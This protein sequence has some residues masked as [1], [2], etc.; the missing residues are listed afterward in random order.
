MHKKVAFFNVRD[1]KGKIHP[2]E[3]LLQVYYLSLS[4][5][6]IKRFVWYNLY[7]SQSVFKF[8]L[9]YTI[10]QVVHTKFIKVVFTSCSYQVH[11][12]CFYKYSIFKNSTKMIQEQAAVV[13]IIALIS[14]K[15]KSRKKRKKEKSLC[16]I[17]A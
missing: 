8:S 3:S 5:S 10:I 16:E 1:I 2:N 14:E 9:R 7:D 4:Q 17:L 12:S 11:K 13:I 6:Y 15:N